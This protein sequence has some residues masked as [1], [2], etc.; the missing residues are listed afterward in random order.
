MKEKK[1]KNAKDTKKWAELIKDKRFYYSAIAATVAALAIVFV[2]TLS[3]VS[4]EEG[5]EAG[6]GNSVTSSDV[7]QSGGDATSGDNSSD[8]N[9]PVDAPQGMALPMGGG[10]LT[11]DHGFFYNQTLNAYYEHAGVDFS[12][13]V[14]TEVCAVAAGTIESIYTG[15]V[16]TGTEITVDHGNGLKTVYRFVDAKEGLSVG[17]SVE[18]GEVIAVVAEPNGDEYKD[19]AHLHFEI[20]E[21]G[22]SVDPATHLPLEEK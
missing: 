7:V 16:L 19:G 21:N 12:A 6:N 17:D 2:A 14:G 13:A 5:S 4:K 1:D 11:N 15:D 8:G 3:A 22:K 18:R 10:T 20:L 9:K